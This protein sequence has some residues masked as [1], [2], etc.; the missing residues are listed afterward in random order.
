VN[1]EGLL[2]KLRERPDVR[3]REFERICKWLLENA[4]EYAARLERVWLWDEWPGRWGADAGIDLVAEDRGGGL[5]AVQ[6]KHYDQAY[7]IRKADLDSFLSESSRPGFS[8]R[9][10]ISSTDHLG[11]TARRTLNAQEKPVGL[12]LRSDLA[13]LGLAW[14]Q[15]L[16]E[17]HPVKARPKKPR[18][19]QRRAIRDIV[20]G[21][22]SR[23]R[24]QVVMACGTGKTLVARFLHDAISSRR[25]LVL[26]PSLS[27]LKQSLRE[28][29][30]VGIFDYLAVCSDDTVTPDDTD[31][32]VA[33]TSEL[34][35]PV[36]T[37]VGEIAS[38]LRRRGGGVVFATY[39]SSPRIAAAQAGRVPAFDLVVA[40]EAHRC[41]GP[42]AGVFAT[43]L[44][45]AKIKARKR[46]FMTATPRYYTGRLRK[47]ASEADWEIASMDDETQ[48]G[49]V[50]HR[51]S[52]SEA[53]E[54]D[55]L[56]DYQVVVVGVTAQGYRE[57]AE[58]GAFVT[59]DGETITDA[60]TLAR[61]IGLL[62]AIR[63]HDL[64]RVVTF[65]TR[66]DSASRFAT[67][68]L[69][70]VEW[71]P[72]ELRPTGD[73]WAEHVSG[74][75]TSG[76]RET[77]LNR[78]R[79]VGV[80]ER[81]ILTNARC[82]AEGVDVPALDGVAFIDPR[83]SQVDVVQAVGRAIRKADDKTVGTIV[84]PVFVDENA[85]PVDALESSE[86][87]RV[88]QIVQALRDHDDFLAD[89]LDELR[90]ELGRRGTEVGRP[91]RIKFDVP[92]GIGESFARAFD[93]KVVETTTAS[94]EFCFGLLQRFA[95]REGHLNVPQQ[96]VEDGYRLGAWINTQRFFRG[97]GR[98]HPDRAARLSALSGWIWDPL[99]ARWEEGYTRLEQ[100]DA[101]E[102]HAR[103]P[104]T[105]EEDGYRLG[106][107]V[108]VQRSFREQGRLSD[109]RAARLDTLPGWAW[110]AKDADWESGY[111]ALERFV[112]HE[113]HASV[114]YKYVE[115]GYRLG[116]W[117]VKQRYRATQR[118][119]RV[120]R[121]EALHGWVWNTKK[122]AW[123]DAFSY[124]ETFV[125]RE[126]HARVPQGHI[127]DDYKLGSWLNKQRSAYRVG[128]LS[129]ERVA[130]LKGLPGW[131]SDLHHKDNAW[132]K[133]YSTLQGFVA[134][135]GHVRVPQGYVE[136]G[137]R[138][139]Q[140]VGNQQAAYLAGRLSSDR[141]ARLTAM[142]RWAWRRSYDDSWEEGFLR[143]Q[144]FI[145]RERHSRVSL[146]HV[147][148]G[149]S[150]GVWVSRQ[151]SA[152]RSNRLSEER[153]ARLD[154]LPGWVWNPN[155]TA[156]ESGYSRVEKYLAREGHAHVPV[157]HVD[158]DG[159]RLGQWVSNQR[160]AHKAG[161]LSKE[162]STRLAALPGWTWNAREARA[163]STLNDRRVSLAVRPHSRARQ[164]SDDAPRGTPSSRCTG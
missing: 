43:V 21:L 152:Y 118:P 157:L 149:Y 2:T 38:F 44:D 124:L 140:W 109:E 159:Y 27:L 104:S 155:A 77:R 146:G 96:H 125:A 67:S 132:E 164:N 94:W 73:L 24:G 35:V 138:L 65:H 62:R 153:S 14:P 87:D 158:D 106:Q 108:V 142:P 163:T 22:D 54:H 33:A 69:G 100:F 15:S 133:G 81:G 23:D 66:I 112:A 49:V 61:Q 1:F 79:A 4:P 131:D 128:R 37:D 56:S 10:L 58:R 42:Q 13:A 68:L 102:G 139:G 136:D 46:V 162:R 17:L 53:I 86:F 93:T 84:I 72:G 130:R 8:Y 51:L 74:K 107:W 75:M 41:A 111:A 135:E 145:T 101:R 64:Q 127:E 20:Q 26:V 63:N 76:E 88:W 28:W 82:L 32:V 7:A 5:W 71:M 98:L 120:A 89:E 16:A 57:M 116:R 52:F 59:I 18:P 9:L 119:D 115:N 110:H 83:R 30:A 31:A 123:D 70:L 141:I 36:T 39:Q 151:R 143:L 92:L 129:D 34:G 161:R 50:L 103:V 156:W 95:N 45:R 105:H 114:P 148:H 80:G 25:T 6:A 11:P 19:H 29:L 144:A 3:G 126:G 160:V 113:G 40:D 147:E 60:R 134:R 99:D 91:A 47:E 122:S 48:F 55:L 121:L 137:Y 150:L 154:A 117:V 90:R 85:D 12:L 78:L 97:V